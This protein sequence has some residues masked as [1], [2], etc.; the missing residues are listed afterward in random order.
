M[1][2][3]VERFLDIILSDYNL[4]LTTRPYS[5]CLWYGLYDEENDYL[6]VGHEIKDDSWY[7]EGSFFG[8]AQSFFELDGK[9]FNKIL[10]NYLNKK[11]NLEIKKLW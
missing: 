11:Y 3:L 4:V 6:F 7:F 2:E 1:E 8:I 10:K 5:G 9:S